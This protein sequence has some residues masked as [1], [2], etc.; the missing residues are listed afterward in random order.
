MAS[1]VMGSDISFLQMIN[2][3]NNMQIYLYVKRFS[4]W[5]GQ[6]FKLHIFSFFAKLQR[7]DKTS[8]HKKQ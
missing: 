5:P 1:K 3:L 8:G 4:M 7:K 6:G 2:V